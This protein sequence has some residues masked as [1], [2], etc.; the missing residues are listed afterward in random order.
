MIFRNRQPTTVSAT[1]EELLWNYETD[2][3]V[4][5]KIFCETSFSQISYGKWEGT[6]GFLENNSE[7]RE[8]NIQ[9]LFRQ[10]HFN[11]NIF[12]LTNIS[13]TIMCIFRTKIKCH[14]FVYF[15]IKLFYFFL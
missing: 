4:I 12:F 15:K 1:M 9:W 13:K 8:N 10:K 14:A 5:I 2:R 11:F 3:R 7:K 6:G